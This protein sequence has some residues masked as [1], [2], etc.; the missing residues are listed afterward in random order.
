[1]KV[2][3]YAASHYIIT[4][5]FLSPSLSQVQIFSS[6]DTWPQHLPNISKAHSIWANLL[7]KSAWILSSLFLILLQKAVSVAWGGT[8]WFNLLLRR[9]GGFHAGTAISLQPFEY[10][11]EMNLHLCP[12]R[13]I[14]F[15]HFLSFFYR[16]LLSP[17]FNVTTL[18]LSRFLISLNDFGCE[19]KK[20]GSAANSITQTIKKSYMDI[21]NS[22]HFSDLSYASL[23]FLSLSPSLTL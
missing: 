17:S 12:T 9:I 18:I 10:R 2:T 22:C 1:V 19:P 7:G 23:C 5:I 21:G 3:S 13:Y 11:K 14:S 6:A 15:L 4:S 8:Y 20:S 16:C